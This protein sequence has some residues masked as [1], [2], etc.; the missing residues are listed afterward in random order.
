MVSCVPYVGGGLVATNKMDIYLCI[1][2]EIDIRCEVSPAVIEY[3]FE[4]LVDGK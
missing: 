4:L 3:V 2:L 1:E